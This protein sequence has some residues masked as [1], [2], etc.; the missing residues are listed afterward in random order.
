ML[1]RLII[2]DDEPVVLHLLSAVFEGLEGIEVVQCATGREA[3]SAMEKGVDILLTDKNLPDIG[4]LELA[5]RARD[6]QSDAEVIV[7]T[8]YAS[9]DT[10]LAALEL[11]VEV[12]VRPERHRTGQIAQAARHSEV[13][14]QA[15]AIELEQQVLAPAVERDDLTPREPG[16]QPARNRPSETRFT[17]GQPRDPVCCDERGEAAARRFDFRQLW[18]VSQA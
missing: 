1:A 11:D 6:F 14:Q 15:A 12:I 10:A 13:D 3:L 8:G 18:H 17:D 9:L 7:I 5:K 16:I 2:V 4:G